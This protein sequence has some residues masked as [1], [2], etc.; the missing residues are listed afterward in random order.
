ME[1]NL[2]RKTFLD[3]FASKQHQIVPSA[4]MVVKGDPTLMFINSGMAPFKEIFLGNAPIKFSRIADTQKCLRVSGKH[5]DLEE[6]GVDTYHHTMFEMLGNWSFGDYFKTEAISWAWQL[7]TEVYKIDKSRLYVT[8]FEG[9]KEDGLAF[10]QEAFDTW[11]EFIDERRILNGNK[12]DN[13]WEMG[14]TGPCGPCSE[15]HYDGRSDEER[16]KTD[17]ALLVNKDNSQ[18]IEIWNNVFMEFERRADGSLVKLPK[19]HV[20][21]GMGFERLVRVLQG[22]QS[23]YDTDVFTPLI[24]KIEELSNH[25]YNSTE[26]EKHKKQQMINIAMRVIADHIRTISFSIADGQLP[27]NTGAGYV[28]RRIL[29][30]AIRYGYQSLNLKEPFMHRIVPTLAHQMGTAFPELKSQKELIEKVIREEEQ[31]FYK[32]LEI[33]LRRIDQVC[34]DINTENKKTIDGKIV[35]ELYDT[36]G[37]PVDLTALIAKGYNLEIDTIGFEKFLKEQKDRSR[38]ATAIDTDDWIYI[39][40]N[41]HY[42]DTQA[43]ETEFIGYEDFECPTHIIRYRKVKTKNKEQFHIVLNKTPFYAESGGQVGD[44][45]ELANINEKIF[46]TDTR[47]ENGVIIHITDKL[48]EKL[49]SEFFAKINYGERVLTTN[50]HT[51]THLL[52]A[53]LRQILGTHV[54][55]KGSLVNSDYLRFDFSHFSKITE[56]ELNEI[57]KTVNQKIRENIKGNISLMAINEAKK[58]G[59]MALFGEKYGDVVRV[60]QFDKNYSIELCGGCHVTYTG[61]IGYFKIISEGAV[62][63]G[64][65]RIE[66]ITSIKAEKYIAEKLQIIDEIKL[67][68][69]NDKDIVKS[70]ITLINDN[71]HLQ[72]QLQ[73]FQKEKAQ[74]LKIIL[75][76]KIESKNNISSIIENVEFENVEETKNILFELKNEVPNLFCVLTQSINLKPSISV[77]ISDNLVK[78]KNLNAGIIVRE[79]AKDIKGGGGGQPFYAQAGGTDVSG[80]P[81]VLHNAKKYLN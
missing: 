76:S 25:R 11:K 65:R 21:T 16:K 51:A 8:V 26:E 66:A 67:L 36:F 44:K 60:V 81:K 80:L 7:L 48:P 35:F 41:K 6:V 14:D 61:Q 55:Q 38:A 40:E 57:E 46:V 78:E 27:G 71:N 34:I 18:V 10:D 20:D 58:L 77:I 13:F 54:E 45:G 72:K 12:K 1:A 9:S 63:A 53:A 50:N 56:I 73:Q 43:L 52:H 19:K 17:G 70:V 22:K 49:S 37:F 79:L 31:S 3:F 59:A 33:G 29:R 24:Y 23:N 5:N 62:A 15:I 42:L 32:T 64:I 68:V 4:P 47:K 69:K 30:R 28:I 74:Q 75:K 39:N 2:V